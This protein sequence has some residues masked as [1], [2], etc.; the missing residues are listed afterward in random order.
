MYNLG[1]PPNDTTSLENYQSKPRGQESG[2]RSYN[3]EV[4]QEE[5]GVGVPSL[6]ETMKWHAPAGF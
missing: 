5:T 1:I 4:S 2:V 3:L 6:L